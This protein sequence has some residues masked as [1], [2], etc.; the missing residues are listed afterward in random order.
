[1]S[2]EQDEAVVRR[3]V[4]SDPVTPLVRPSPGRSATGSLQDRVLKLG[5][6][7]LEVQRLPREVEPGAYPRS[8]AAV[9]VP[10]ELDAVVIRVVK[11][12]GLVRAVVGGAVYGPAAL[13]QAFEGGGQVTAR[14]IV[15]G[16]V[17]EAGRAA[18]GGRPPSLSHVFRPTWWW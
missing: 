18:G 12:D 16:E 14:R 17:V 15:D 11:V 4:A 10:G 2:A 7:A 9:A 3:F 1:M 5:E 8:L 6:Q 13:E